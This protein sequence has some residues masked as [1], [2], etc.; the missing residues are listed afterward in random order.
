MNPREIYK[1]WFD[2]P[3]S[4][5][6]EEYICMMSEAKFRE[7]YCKTAG[8]NI[9]ELR[10]MSN[11]FVRFSRCKNDEHIRDNVSIRQ[12]NFIHVPYKKGLHKD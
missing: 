10:E 12:M 9:D 1:R 2:K 5:T 4:I 8:K 6:A 3:H 11:N 7:H